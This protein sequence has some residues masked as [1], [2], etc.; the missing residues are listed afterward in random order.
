MLISQIKA[1]IIQFLQKKIISHIMYLPKDANVISFIQNLIPQ[2]TF[3][4]TYPK[5]LKYFI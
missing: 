3:A 1:K 4:F 2:I 5:S